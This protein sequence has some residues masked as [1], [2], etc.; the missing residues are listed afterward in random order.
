MRRRTLIGLSAA[1]ITGIGAECASGEGG[2]GSG[3]NERDP[4]TPPEPWP[5]QDDFNDKLRVVTISAWVEPG[6]GPYFVKMSAVDH[7][8]GERT[9]PNRDPGDDKRGERVEGGKQFRFT[10]AYP[11]RHRVELSITATATKPSARGYI[12]TRDG[13]RHHRSSAFGGTTTSSLT[14]TTQR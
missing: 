12:A 14:I 3:G 4:N 1:L 8:T 9:E 11:S 6:S 13:R 5:A 7:D 10:L 2:G